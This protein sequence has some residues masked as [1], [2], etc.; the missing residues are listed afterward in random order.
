M[1]FLKIDGSDTVRQ[2]IGNEQ[3]GITIETPNIYSEPN[4][5]EMIQIKLGFDNFTAKLK[6]AKIISEYIDTHYPDRTIWAM[7]LFKIEKVFIKT[8][9]NTA[10]HNNLEKGV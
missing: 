6:K 3:T 5:S 9:V 2:I 8:K 4:A 7:D 10:L 1:D